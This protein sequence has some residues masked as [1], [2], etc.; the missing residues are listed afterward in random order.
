[1]VMAGLS[2]RCPAIASHLKKAL[3]IA[4]VFAIELKERSLPSGR[5]LE[6]S[7]VRNSLSRLM[8]IVST[9]ASGPRKYDNLRSSRW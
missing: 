3:I 4:L 2:G 7:A 5:S 8:S 6:M 1:M 9:N